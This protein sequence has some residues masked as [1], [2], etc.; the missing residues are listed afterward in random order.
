VALDP[1]APAASA[2]LA[3]SLKK[4][5]GDKMKKALSDAK[6]NVSQTITTKWVHFD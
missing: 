6:L 3:S 5:F 2:A 4:A 1:P